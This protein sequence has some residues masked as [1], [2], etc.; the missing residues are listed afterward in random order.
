MGSNNSG[1]S[2]IL[3]GSIVNTIGKKLFFPPGLSQKYCANFLD[4]KEACKFGRNYNCK[5]CNFPKEYPSNDI[6]SMMDL[7]LKTR[8]LSWNPVPRLP[9]SLRE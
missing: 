8:G 1:A 4:T 9:S 6:A 5:H 3:A 2:T 7:V